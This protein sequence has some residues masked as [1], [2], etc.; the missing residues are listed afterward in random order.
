MESYISPSL[1]QLVEI[2]LGGFLSYIF[3]HVWVGVVTEAFYV[4][5]LNCEFVIINTMTE[6]ASLSFTVSGRM[7]Y[8]LTHDFWQ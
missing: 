2:L 3:S 7:D 8:E 1:S 6:V 5:F 4:V